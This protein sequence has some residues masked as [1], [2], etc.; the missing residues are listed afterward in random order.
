MLDARAQS[1]VGR[2]EEDVMVAQT[3]DGSTSSGSVAFDTPKTC[4][5]EWPQVSKMRLGL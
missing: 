1:I 4:M 3:Q 2:F 5:E